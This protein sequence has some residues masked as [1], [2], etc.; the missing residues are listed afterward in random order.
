MT[1]CPEEKQATAAK[2]AAAASN[3]V[4]NGRVAEENDEASGKKTQ[5][6]DLI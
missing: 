4:R 3:L 2:G 1:T 6:S 5:V